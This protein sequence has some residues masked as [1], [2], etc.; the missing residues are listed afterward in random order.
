MNKLFCF[1][2]IFQLSSISHGQNLI[3]NGDFEQY[4]H[5]PTWLTQ[6]DTA[7][8]WINPSEWPPGG[9]PEY[10]NQCAAGTSVGIPL[11]DFGEQLAHSGTGYAGLALWDSNSPFREYIE[12]PLLTPLTANL[13]YHFEMYISLA[14]EFTFTTDDVGVYF[15]D[16]LIDGI[17]NFLPLPYIAQLNNP[18]GNFPDTLN[19]TLVSGDYTAFGGENYLLIGNFKD[20]PNT[21]LIQGNPGGMFNSVYIYVDDVSLFPATGIFQ[22]NDLTGINVYPNPFSD[23]LNIA[24]KI[25]EQ[26]II[27]I[28]DITSRILLQQTFTNSVI[29]NTEQYPK[30]VYIYEVRDRN[31]M[32]QKGKIVKE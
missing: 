4:N 22:P 7:L 18:N 29:L 24:T 20:D 6:L 17:M 14:D 3:P 9:S 19:W 13:T 32:T 21:T 1:I 10:F 31:G 12:T 5:C 15:S 25:N 27:N 28:Y 26:L 11:N 8:F 2:I 23:Q 30:G 16:T